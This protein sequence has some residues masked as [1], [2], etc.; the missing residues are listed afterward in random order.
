MYALIV[1]GVVERLSHPHV[2]EEVERDGVAVGQH[3]LGD[4]HVHADL[5]HLEVEDAGVDHSMLDGLDG[6]HV[7]GADV[8]D[9]VFPRLEA[10]GRRVDDQ[11]PT[12]RQMGRLTPVV[13]IDVEG[14]A[15]T[16]LPRGEGVRTGPHHV[17]GHVLVGLA[18]D[19]ATVG[20]D[21]VLADDGC[22]R[23][24]GEK[25]EEGGVNRAQ[26][27]LE[28]QVVDDSRLGN[29]GEELGLSFRERH[30]HDAIPRVLDVLGGHD[31]C[32]RRRPRP[33]GG[34]RCR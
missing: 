9:V 10:R 13:G 11:L 18:G 28:G 23:V 29:V 32:R 3:T 21:C 2:L 22:H 8:D 26:G 33:H 17:L 4:V 19:H 15:V 14:H 1:E 34:G 12:H 16:A 5:E 7:G 20:F 6:R 25:G 24:G 31:R 30:L 27:H